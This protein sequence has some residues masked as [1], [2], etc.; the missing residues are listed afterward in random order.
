MLAIDRLGA[1]LSD[2]PDPYT[3]HQANLQ[4]LIHHEIVQLARSGG[5]AETGGVAIEKV[6]SP[7]GFF[8]RCRW[9]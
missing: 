4:T 3:V 8:R 5:I 7:W 9:Y 6:R 2:H 1:G